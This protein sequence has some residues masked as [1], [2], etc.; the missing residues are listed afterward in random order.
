MAYP[1]SLGTTLEAMHLLVTNGKDIVHMVQSCFQ[2]GIARTSAY[3]RY[4]DLLL[5]LSPFVSG[6]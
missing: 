3:S 1:L 4:V 2:P 6:L 5:F